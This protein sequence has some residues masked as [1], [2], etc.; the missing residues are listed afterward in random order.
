MHWLSPFFYM[1][2]KFEPLEK[3][4]DKLKQLTTIEPRFFRR[5][6]VCTPFDHKRNEDVVEEL[7]V[8]LLTTN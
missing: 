8:E 5:T 1:K 3:K 7:K 2:A 4:N 6:A